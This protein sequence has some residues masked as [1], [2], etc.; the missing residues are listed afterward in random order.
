MA[1]AYGAQY[2]DIDNNVIAYNQYQNILISGS[3][4]DHN[5]VRYNQILGGTFTSPPVGYDN[6]GVIITDGAQHNTIG[7]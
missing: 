6:T 3:G 4:T 1:I 5:T 2:N 7:P